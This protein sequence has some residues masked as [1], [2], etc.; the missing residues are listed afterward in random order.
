MSLLPSSLLAADWLQFRGENANGIVTEP[1][2][3]QQWSPSSQVAWQVNIPGEGWSAPIVV[4][5]K[6]ILTTAISQGGKSR[7]SEHEWQIICLDEKTGKELWRKTALKGK[8]P[9]GTHRDNTYATETPASDGEHVVV[10]FGMIGL[11]CYDLNGTE[12]WKKDL[13]NFPMMADWGTSS[14]PVIQDGL[15]YLQ[16]DNE[17]QSFV[18]ALDVKTGEEK[19]RKPR[20]EKSNWGSP[21][22]GR[23]A[24]GQN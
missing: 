20:D 14:S 9:L 19:W 17:Q 5:G 3:V 12:V 22:F 21:W 8:P 15:T 23:T 16:I 1:G 24:K 2:F 11:F 4:K 7:D 13:G 18:V 10:Y 6:V